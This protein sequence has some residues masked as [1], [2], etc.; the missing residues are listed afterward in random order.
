[1]E[2][3]DYPDSAHRPDTP[4]DAGR[5]Q[6]RDGRGR[7]CFGPRIS[8]YWCC[9]VL[10]N[11]LLAVFALYVLGFIMEADWG[12]LSAVTF[13]TVAR[14]AYQLLLICSP[15]LLTLLLN[16][17]LYRIVRG[18]RRFPRGT[19]LLAVIVALAVQALVIFLLLRSGSPAG[20]EGFDVQSFAGPAS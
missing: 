14:A 15:A 19:G 12:F 8:V 3:R 13:E 10:L 4:A 17:L 11:L 7:L 9:M 18:R 6:S 5:G 1:M 20:V 16:R 2:R